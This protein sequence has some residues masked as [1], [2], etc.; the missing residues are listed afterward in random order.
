MANRDDRKIEHS[1]GSFTFTCRADIGHAVEA[2]W[3]GEVW[4]GRGEDAFDAAESGS[5]VAEFIAWHSLNIL[6]TLNSFQG[7]DCVRFNI[8]NGT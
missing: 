4:H 2:V 1:A 5:A 6:P 8:N 7:Y 3:Q